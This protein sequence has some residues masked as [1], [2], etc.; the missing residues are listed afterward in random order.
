M[1]EAIK[2]WFKRPI[3]INFMVEPLSPNTAINV[4]K[5]ESYITPEVAEAFR[6]AW[7]EFSKSKAVVLC[8]G[9]Q[10]EQLTD[11]QLKAIGLM[12]VKPGEATQTTKRAIPPEIQTPPI[13][14]E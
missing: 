13:K 5:T 1:F 8:P 9:I 4:L 12:R 10:I 11:Y 2:K 14:L 6:K 3:V 7:P